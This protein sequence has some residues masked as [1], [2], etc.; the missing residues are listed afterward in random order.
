MKRF[1]ASTVLA[2]C[3]LAG[4]SFAS[5]SALISAT[6]VTSMSAGSCRTA[7]RPDIRWLT[8]LDVRE[9]TRLD[10]W[11]SGV[12]PALF[13]QTPA[14]AEAA[15]D[16]VLFVSWNVH[17][18][19]GDLERFVDDLRAGRLSDGRRPRHL[20]LML[21][22]A[23]RSR[24]V[25]KSIPVSASTAG[26]IGPADADAVDIGRVAE[27]LQMSVFY[28]PS[29][30]DGGASASY[31]PADRGNAILST[32]PLV[33]AAA[34]E[35]PGDGQ[36][37]VAAT[38]DITVTID[39]HATTMTL[40]S[41][42]LSTRT[43]AR[44]LWIVGARGQR[45]E[46]ARAIAAQTNEHALMILGADL[47]TWMGGA[48]EPAA[49][50]LER[51]FPSTPNGPREATSSIGRVLDYL[52]FRAPSGW[53]PR[54]IRAAD[55]YGSDHYPLLGWVERQNTSENIAQNFSSAFR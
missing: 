10:A 42:H 17:V 3:V 31:E 41:A 16:E 35:L 34:I 26:R 28:V 29:M 44:T 52:F 5:R 30:R 36:R 13:H 32:I 46:Q 22:E 40:G 15:L 23:V 51:A 8:P 2:A 48:D 27:R 12:G 21:Q 49:Q 6:D 54:M 43:T 7:S 38:A 55:Q 4:C 47:N 50:D 18:G 9:H 20:V 37:R 53:R 1:A 39:G 24:D 25:P 33:N 45:Q 19:H 11:C 14:D